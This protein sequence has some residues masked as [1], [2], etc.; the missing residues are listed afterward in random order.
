VLAG[1]IAASVIASVLHPNTTGGTAGTAAGQGDD[2]SGGSG[3]GG[4]GGGG[5]GSAAAAGGSGGS[6]GG[7]SGGSGTAANG[8]GSSN[9]A[10]GGGSGVSG[11]AANGSGSVANAS[12]SDGSA[13]APNGANPGGSSAGGGSGRTEGAAA[14]A[15]NAFLTPTKAPTNAQGQAQLAPYSVLSAP[16][17]PTAQ[18]TPLFGQATWWG[19]HS[20]FPQ[21][22]LNQ[23]GGN[24]PGAGPQAPVATMASGDV[25]MAGSPDG[26]AAG[27]AQHP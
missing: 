11:S 21:P 26:V 2:G 16:P 10:G 20:P 19:S 6:G 25:D 7:G 8:G 3:Y 18:M 9:G 24:A 27:A 17:P 14:G 12:G 13:G 22:Q 4:G 1:L 5:S 15:E 23:G